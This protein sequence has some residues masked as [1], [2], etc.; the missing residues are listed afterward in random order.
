LVLIPE[1]VLET[2]VRKF[3]YR[4]IREHLIK[5]KDLPEE[6]STWEGE[7]IIAHPSL[8]L[9]EGK[10]SREGRLCDV[11][12]GPLTKCVMVTL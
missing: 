1:R 2:K 7:D 9:L 8:R 6:D 3:K 12:F 4:Q 5:W 11:P 10:Q